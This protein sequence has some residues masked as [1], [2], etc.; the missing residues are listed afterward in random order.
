MMAMDKKAQEAYDIAVSVVDRMAG[1]KIIPKNKA[2][3]HKSRLLKHI[4]AMA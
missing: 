1:K 2:A 4:R 3:R